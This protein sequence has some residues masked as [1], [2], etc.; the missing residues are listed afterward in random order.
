[1][2]LVWT[3][4]RTSGKIRSALHTRPEDIQRSAH[5]PSSRPAR[6][7]RLS[8]YPNH[9]GSAEKRIETQQI[10]PGILTLPG[11]HIEAGESPTG[12]T[13]RTPQGLRHC[14]YQDSLCL[15][16]AP[17]CPGVP[18]A[19]LLRGRTL[20]GRD[21]L[22]KAA[23][24]LWVFL[25]QVHRFALAVDRV[26]INEYTRVSTSTSQPQYTGVSVPRV[27]EGRRAAHRACG[28]V[29]K[30]ARGVGVARREAG[31]RRKP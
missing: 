20:A 21:Q 12:T 4:A 16:A 11:Y 24:L 1:M 15:H 25:N 27:C 31:A 9:Q 26:A 29:T 2:P 8:T 18:E 28:V 22:S 6:L 5:G 3:P 10:V 23:T 19:A 14:A 13:T 30:R 7:R 17:A